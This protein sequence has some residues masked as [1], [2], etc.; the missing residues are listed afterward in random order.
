MVSSRLQ[1]LMQKVD[2]LTDELIS[3]VSVQQEEIDKLKHENEKLKI[4]ATTTLDQVQDYIAELEQIKKS[5]CQ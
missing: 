2:K 3:K 5:L 1:N 4:L